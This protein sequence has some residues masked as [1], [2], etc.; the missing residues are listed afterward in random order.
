MILVDA[1]SNDELS[2][3]LHGLPFWGI[4]KT[5]VTPLESYE[6]RGALDRE[7]VKKL[8]AMAK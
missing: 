3:L 8:K 7:L 1:A 5:N 2:K 4:V 6:H